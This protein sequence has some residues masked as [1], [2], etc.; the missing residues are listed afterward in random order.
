MSL[1]CSWVG[2]GEGLA[3]TAE[4]DRQQK[5]GEAWQVPGLS[6]SGQCLP[7]LPWTQ[8]TR[9]GPLFPEL[10]GGTIICAVLTRR[11]PSA[12]IQRWAGVSGCPRQCS[13]VGG[14]E[15]QKQRPSWVRFWG[16]I[17]QLGLVLSGNVL[18]FAEPNKSST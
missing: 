2:R 5:L 18:P 12:S 13:C 7:A 4:G 9:V 10:M 15:K 11:A 8:Q 1:V 6:W 17:F 14:T 3:L 16:V